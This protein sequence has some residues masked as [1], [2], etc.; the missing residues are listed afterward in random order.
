MADEEHQ[1]Y[2]HGGFHGV[3]EWDLNLSKQRAA[4]QYVSPLDFADAYALLRQREETLRYLER[5]YE[6]HEP[7]LVYITRQ[8]KS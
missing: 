4:K 8:R 6:I 3:L 1:A 7:F 5:A 2:T